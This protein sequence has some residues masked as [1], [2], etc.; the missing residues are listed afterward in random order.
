MLADPDKLLEILN[1]LLHNAMEY[2]KPDG[3]IDLRVEASPREVVLE[4]SDTGIGIAPPV[5]EQ[6]FQRFF[7]ADPSRHADGPHV[8]LGLAIVKSFVELMGGTIEVES[9]SA[10]STFRVRLPRTIPE[11]VA[12]HRHA[13]TATPSVALSR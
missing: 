8:G 6:I 4:V 11:P 12:D 13:I 7:R 2:N 10:G 1:N 3:S 9:N 5:K